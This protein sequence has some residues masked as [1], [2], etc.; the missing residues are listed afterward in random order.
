VKI[1]GRMRSPLYIYLASKIY[2]N[3]IKRAKEG[4]SHLLTPREKE[5]LEIVFNRGFSQGYLL[6]NNVMQREY[7]ESRGL[8]LNTAYSAGT[9]ITVKTKSLRP[10]DG[11]TLYRNNEKIGGFEVKSFKRENNCMLL[12]SPF[13]IPRGEYNLYKTR[14]QAFNSIERMIDAIEFRLGQ[15]KIEHRNL[16]VPNVT[17]KIER[18][19]LSF[20]VSSLKSLETVLPYADRI[21]FEWNN[22]FDEAVEMCRKKKVECVL[23]APSLSFKLLNVDV[24]NLMINSVDQFQKYSGRRLYGYYSMNFFNSL[25]I[26]E[27]YQYTISVELSRE[28]IRE[29]ARH[30]SQRLEIMVFGRLELMVTRDLTLCEGLLVDQ[31]GKRFPVYRDRFGFAHILNSSDLFLLDFLGEIEAMGINSFGIDLRRR[32]AE[33]SAIVARVFHEGDLS[34]KKVIKK[35]CGSITAGHYL[36]G[37]M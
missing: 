9:E 33:L 21:Y 2:S 30:Y 22:H 37:V 11:I 3:A 31:K 10:G 17:R 7:P 26:P 28:E 4:K 14:D 29:I 16:V 5:M 15:G 32:S 35:K 24:Y 8:F 13:W 23:L 36:R 27:L 34:K 25:T 19:Q 18:A 20:Y 1:E 12:R 6:E